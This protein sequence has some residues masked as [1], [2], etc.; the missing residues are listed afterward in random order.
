MNKTEMR[1]FHIRILNEEKADIGLHDLEYIVDKAANAIDTEVRN[2]KGKLDRD[3]LTKFNGKKLSYKGK[4]TKVTDV[5]VN[6]S[7]SST[8][9]VFYVSLQGFPGWISN[10]DL[11]KWIRD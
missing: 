9:I 2:I 5:S 11:E 7:N 3:L 4:D 10:E 6:V 1:P 8:D